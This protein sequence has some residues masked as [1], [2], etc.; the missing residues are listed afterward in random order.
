MWDLNQPQDVIEMMRDG[1]M[2]YE[3]IINVCKQ[4][5]AELEG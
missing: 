1:E 5:I 3:Q 4:V 2:S